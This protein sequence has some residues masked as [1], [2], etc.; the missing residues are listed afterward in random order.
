MLQIRILPRGIKEHWV[1]TW[2]IFGGLLIVI[3]YQWKKEDL[4]VIMSKNKESQ[5]F[6]GSNEYVAAVFLLT[7]HGNSIEHS[8][9]QDI[10]TNI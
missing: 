6:V 10:V 2:K 1:V 4:N 8:D 7:P 3:N 5:F 9:K